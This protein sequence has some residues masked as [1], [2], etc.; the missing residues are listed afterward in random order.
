MSGRVLSIQS[1]VT[2][3]YVGTL[4]VISLVCEANN[5]VNRKQGYDTFRYLSSWLVQRASI[6]AATF[7]LQVLGYDV[8]A[9]NTV[10]Y[11]NHAGQGSIFRYQPFSSSLSQVTADPAASRP[12]QK[13]WIKYS[14]RWKGIDFLYLQ[15][16]WLLVGWP[17]Y[18]ST[19]YIPQ[20]PPSQYRL[21]SRRSQSGSRREPYYRPAQR[22]Q[23]RRSLSLRS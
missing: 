11:T 8:D 22:A 7:P 1:H 2:S 15:L 9:V 20:S 19:F 3:G 13:T 4:L 14:I 23:S 6:T 21:Y 10:Q 18:E 5:P 16:E 17:P 12:N